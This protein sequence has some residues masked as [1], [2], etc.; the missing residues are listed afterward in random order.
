MDLLFLRKRESI[1][2]LCW[3]SGFHFRIDIENNPNDKIN[4]LVFHWAKRCLV[5]RRALDTYT[6]AIVDIKNFEIE[7][8][9]QREKQE[10]IVIP[11]LKVSLRNDKSTYFPSTCYGKSIYTDHFDHYIKN[12]TLLLGSDM[13]VIILEQSYADLTFVE[14]CQYTLLWGNAQR[15]VKN[16]VFFLL[17][18]FNKC[19]FFSLKKKESKLGKKN[20]FL[21][22]FKSRGIGQ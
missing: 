14:Y 21:T 12:I 19:T 2:T 7:Y 22:Q 8:F 10:R 6:K 5:M 3:R 18:K 4:Y 20:I 13:K 15:F 17:C 11:S 9:N 16:K 1:I